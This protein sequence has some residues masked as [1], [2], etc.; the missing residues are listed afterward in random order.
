M[1]NTLLSADGSPH[2]HLLFPRQQLTKN[3][4]T[5]AKQV[6]GSAKINQLAREISHMSHQQFFPPVW[7]P[8][9]EAG[10]TSLI[11]VFFSWLY[12]ANESAA[13]SLD[14]ILTEGI[15]AGLDVD[16][17]LR[18]DSCTISAHWTTGEE[19][20]IY[21]EVEGGSPQVQ[22]SGPLS[23]MTQNNVMPITIDPTCIDTSQ[24]MEL[25]QIMGGNKEYHLAG[26][27]DLAISEYPVDY[28][29][30]DFY[31]PPES[32]TSNAT[33]FTVTTMLYGYGY[34]ST[35][36][37]IKLSVVTIAVYCIV[38]ISYITYILITGST[39]TAWS[40]A[41]ELVAL[42]LQS[43]K[44]DHLGHTSVGI[45]SL[46]TFKQ[47]VGIRINK[48]NELELVFDRDDNARNLRKIE[49]NKAY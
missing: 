19:Q 3:L 15:A 6:H 9:P 21:S 36:V 29:G 24:G 39:S 16:S 14:W 22:T 34:N 10:S 17:R 20:M 23:M 42:A 30:M 27:F 8:S 25:H 46:D 12:P 43:K 45:D 4:S 33:A 18:V 1:Q 11:G 5:L 26:A 44:P 40:S 2:Q 28:L 13:P 38:T 41:V 31:D 48:D 37:S 47:G 49:K 35:S 7:M 32:D